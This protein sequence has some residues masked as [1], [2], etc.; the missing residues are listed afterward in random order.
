MENL[1]NTLFLKYSL[2]LRLFLTQFMK[3]K[4]KLFFVNKFSI[5]KNEKNNFNLKINYT[6]FWRE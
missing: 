4:R 3:I 5:K 1:S 6:V 2:K